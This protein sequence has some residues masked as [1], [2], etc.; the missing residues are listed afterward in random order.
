MHPLNNF[1]SVTIEINC[2]NNVKCLNYESVACSL[3]YDYIV[4]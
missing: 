4:F 3:H 1:A 2:V